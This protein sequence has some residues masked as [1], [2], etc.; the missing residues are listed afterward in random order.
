MDRDTRW[1]RVKTAWDCYVLG[2]GET[3]DDPVAA[4][5]ASYAAGVT[6][7]F[8][9]PL[10]IAQDFPTTVRDGDGVFFFN[11]RA[12]R[13]RELV[14]PFLLEDFAGFDRG[15][16]PRLCAMASMTSYDAHF[17]LPVAFPK[18]SV[19]DG[20]GATVSAHGLRQLRLAETEKYAHVT[21]FFNGGREEPFENENRILVD[22]PRDV[23]TYDLKPAMSALEVT[24]VFEREWGKGVH[25][26][27]V[28]NLANGDM[29]GHTGVLAAAVTACETVD[30]CVGRMRKAV[31]DRGGRMLIIAD[32]GN[33]ETMLT[34]EGRP[35]TAHTTNPVPCILLDS[36]G[37]TTRIA[38]GGLA[39]VATTILGL[40][41]IPPSGPMQGKNLAS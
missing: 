9:R 10:R 15:T 20:L 41:G 12:D 2:I 24:S 32:H 5:K 23:A 30:L 18:Q 36:D 27:V 6:D 40:W 28:C 14:Q 8:I 1:D 35:H 34:P 19:D 39:D 22:S 11:F 37:G 26:L 17:A 25:D 29:V 3:A 33:C 7:E 38:D 31:A 4:L 13:M 16:L 21:Y